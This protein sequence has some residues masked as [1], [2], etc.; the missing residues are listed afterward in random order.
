[1]LQRT[2]ESIMMGASNNEGSEKPYPFGGWL[3]E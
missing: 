1:M 2:D 3:H